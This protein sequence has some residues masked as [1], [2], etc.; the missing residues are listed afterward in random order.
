MPPVG[1]L[2]SL[3]L[4]AVCSQ[5]LKSNRKLCGGRASLIRKGRGWRSPLSDRAG[6]RRSKPTPS[7]ATSDQSSPPN[8]R[9]VLRGSG[10]AAAIVAGGWGCVVK[11]YSATSISQGDQDSAGRAACTAG[12]RGAVTKVQ[13]PSGVHGCNAVKRT[14]RKNDKAALQM[15][16]N[17]LGMP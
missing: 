9:R 4:G 17:Q 1:E 16:G 6:R 3:A 12:A 13:A 8:S 2:R 15:L 14:G 10:G 11:G 5:Q 7:G